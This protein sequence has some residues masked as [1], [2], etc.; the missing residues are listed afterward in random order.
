MEDSSALI[1]HH[2]KRQTGIHKEDKTR[3]K[4]VLRLFLQE[5]FFA[6]TGELSD[7]EQDD[8][9]EEESTASTGKKNEKLVSPSP[10]PILKDD[11]DDMYNLIFVNN[12]WYILLRLH[13]VRA[14]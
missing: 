8:D 9:N 12:T 6:P 13:Q 10:T 11:D 5:L 4:T 1:I 14:F 3:I 7:D 2:M